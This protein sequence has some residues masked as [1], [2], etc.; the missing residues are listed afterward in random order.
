[1]NKTKIILLFVATFLMFISC[2]ETE[3]QRNIRL[4]REE[5]QRI[6][7]AHKIEQEHIEKERQKE[8]KRIEQEKQEKIEQLAREEKR[9]AQEIYDK[10]INNYLRT[11]STPYS[12]QYGGNPS[13]ND[14]DCS[15]ISVK[16]PISSDVLV[17]IK[18]NNKVVRHAYIRGGNSYTF[19]MSNGTYQPFFYYGK[20]WNPEKV[21][22]ET[23]KGTL[24][25]G[26]VANELFSKDDPQHLENQILEYELILQP[27]GNFNTLPSN[28]NDAL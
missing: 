27:N 4:Q 5:K 10:Y 23:T 1:M 3:Q 22:K 28:A 17:T 19:S 15:Q 26:F 6:E 13:C 25:G 16:T 8:A 11:G 21:M 2:G 9:K 24:K 18:R 20:G 7:M 14:Y 12:K